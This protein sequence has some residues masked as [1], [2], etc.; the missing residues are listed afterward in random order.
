MKS[1]SCGAVAVCLIVCSQ[2]AVSQGRTDSSAL[3]PVAVVNQQGEPV[4]QVTNKVALL[5]FPC[6]CAYYPMG[7]YWYGEYF[8]GNCNNPEPV[9]VYGPVGPSSCTE[10]NCGCDSAVRLDESRVPDCE[11]LYL[12]RPVDWDWRPTETTQNTIV[13]RAKHLRIT[14]LDGKENEVEIY[15]VAYKFKFNH[16]EAKSKFF[17]VGYECEAPDEGESAVPRRYRNLAATTATQGPN[18]PADCR[19]VI[20][21]KVNPNEQYLIQTSHR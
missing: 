18:M 2:F 19:A 11:D 12:L 1:L 9:P 10:P 7:P 6:V 5:A 20:V 21:V 4:K 13:G 8:E 3:E 16:G 17:H 14:T 15:V